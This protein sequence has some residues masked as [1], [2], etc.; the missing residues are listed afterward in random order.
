[1]VSIYN[2][3][4]IWWDDES[5]IFT[6]PS[7]PLPHEKIRVVAR[8][9]KSGSTEIFTRFLSSVSE[10]WS[11][12]IGVFSEGL[13]ENKKPMF[14]NSSIIHLYGQT[15]RGMTGIV[16]SIEYSIGYTVLADAETSSLKTASIVNR[17][18]KTITANTTTIQNA[19][20]DFSH[21]DTLLNSIVDPDGDNSYPISAYTYLIVKMQ[22]MEDCDSAIE[23]VGYINWLLTAKEAREECL[24]RF[25]VPLSNEVVDIIIETVLKRM[26]CKGRAVYKTMLQKFQNETQSAETW[27]LSL[28]ILI[29]CL[30]VI[31]IGLLGYIVRDQINIHKAL[32]R[33]EWRIPR[34]ELQDERHMEVRVSEFNSIRNTKLTLHSVITT[35]SKN[36]A[37]NESVIYI[38]RRRGNMVA[39][40]LVGSLS[41]NVNIFMKRKLLTMRDL[42]KHNNVVRFYGLTEQDGNFLSVSEFNFR[43]TLEG[44]LTIYKNN[45]NTISQTAIAY[46]IAH[47]MSYLHEKRIV[48]GNLRALNCFVDTKWCIKVGN[49]TQHCLAQYQQSNAIQMLKTNDREN[50]MKGHF[51]V[52][53]EIIKFGRTPTRC[54]DVYSYAMT[55][56]E[57][58]TYEQPYVELDQMT[59]AEIIN[60]ICS[61]DLRPEFSQSTPKSLR[62]LMELTW[63]MEPSARPTF[64]SILATLKCASPG[65]P[66]VIDCMMESLEKHIKELEFTTT[67]HLSNLRK[68]KQRSD[69]YLSGLVPAYI[70]NKLSMGCEVKT[71]L[72]DNLTTMYMILVNIGDII[73]TIA[74]EHVTDILNDLHVGLE[75][76]FANSDFCCMDQSP[77]VFTVTSGITPSSKNHTKC[78]SI[79][80][81]TCLDFASNF[82]LDPETTTHLSLKIG[83]SSGRIVAG[84]MGTSCK[85]YFQIGSALQT[86]KE[87]A[88]AGSDNCIRISF[89]TNLQLKAFPTFIVHE[90]EHVVRTYLIISVF[91]VYIRN[92]Y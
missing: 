8:S 20:Y 23:L 76:L 54:S 56:Q 12:Y 89:Q 86:A 88:N 57:I 47:G 50:Y 4:I 44:F 65:K 19:M 46:D 49:W 42:I 58:F 24:N 62:D 27:R 16:L 41:T 72:F 11:N 92:I 22:G 79:I 80:A 60:C 51:W 67:T 34:D 5:L 25:M 55:L 73:Q 13:D 91:T 61:S 15:T 85:R 7:I 17:A 87:L 43:F 69:I 37:W 68:E 81:L 28:I 9:D 90:V 48:H 36:I 77:F 26:T 40:A 21:I 39:M 82:L 84:M 31:F 75:N 18:K 71:E 74:I 64:V 38:A 53:P 2:G 52:A 32:I 29:P 3:S 70:A 14:W 63:D 78:M 35:P 66:S 45:L 83:M 30:F 6:N 1:M 33:N 59:S 10:E